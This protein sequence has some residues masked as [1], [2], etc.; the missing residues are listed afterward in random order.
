M[1]GA[2]HC[3]LYPIMTHVSVDQDTEGVKQQTSLALKIQTCFGDW[4]S[5]L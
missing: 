3:F 2:L 1:T 5:S 4:H